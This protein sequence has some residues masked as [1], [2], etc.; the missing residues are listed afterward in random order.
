MKRLTSIFLVLAMLL[1]LAPMNI[2]A[3]ESENTAFSDMKITDYYA[4][5]ATV[6]EELG[7]ISGYPD[8]TYGAEKSITRAEMAAIICRII[9]K[10]ADADA[11][12]GETAFDDVS[13][14]H[15]ASGYI[16]VA[17]KLGIINGD[18]DGNFRPEDEVKFEEAIKMLVCALGYAD[19]VE[20]DENDWSKAYLEIAE[21]KGIT[22]SLQGEK[23]KSATRGDIAV[24]SYNG[25]SQITGISAIPAVPVASVSGGEYE[26]AQKVKLTTITEGAEIYYTTD[27]TTPTEKSVKYTKEISISKTC[28]LKAVAVKNGVA[29]KEILSVDYTIL[30]GSTHTGRRNS[31]SSGSSSS[32]Y[33]VTFDLNYDG[34]TGTPASQSVAKDG[35]AT[36][37][38]A[39]VR[40]GYSFVGWYMDNTYSTLF[41]FS[42]P[43][44]SDCTVFARWIDITDSTDTDG[45]GLSDALE[46]YYG[47]DAA[48]A[49]TDGDGLTD[50][51]EIKFSNTNPLVKDSDE[52][53]VNDCDED[54]D[55]D[56]LKNIEE[57]AYNCNP[58][59]NDTDMDG[60]SDYDEIKVYNTKPD[61]EDTDGDGLSDGDEIELGLNPL[62]QK[63]DGE[64]LD[65]QR[66]FAQTL[67]EENISDELLSAE[68]AA[69]PSLSMNVAGNIESNT[70]VTE[71][72]YEVLSANKAVVGTP[73]S[74]STTADIS[75]GQATISFNISGGALP[76][77]LAL[78]EAEEDSQYLICK[79]S[80][81][82]EETEFE[83]L[84]TT[85]EN[86]ILSA[87][88]DSEGTYF[89][90]DT[91]SFLTNL[92][93]YPLDYFDDAEP[94]MLMSAA[95]ENSEKTLIPHASISERR[96]NANKKL[97]NVDEVA[98]DDTL[99]T[100]EEEL[101]LMSAS[102]DGVKAQADIVFIIDKTGS[103]FSAIN[104]VALNVNKFADDLVNKYK[105][106]ANFSIIEFQDITHDGDDSTIQHKNG[107]SNWWNA[108]SVNLFKNEINGL[109]PDDGGD[110]P[111]TPIDG[112]GMARELVASS[113]TQKFFILITDAPYKEDNNYGV[114]N[115][116]QMIDLLKAD[117]INVSVVTDEWNEWE[118][119]ESVGYCVV[120]KTKY[121]E[122]YYRLTDVYYDE[123]EGKYFYYDED[124]ETY[125]ETTVY[126]DKSQVK[127][128]EYVGYIRD[129]DGYYKDVYYNKEAD[130]YYSISWTYDEATNSDIYGEVDVIDTSAI[131]FTSGD[132]ETGKVVGYKALYEKT[133]G[134]FGNIYDSNFALTLD[135]IAGMIDDDV[136]DG[137]WI[138]LDNFET[139]KLEKAPAA[140]S[141][142]DTDKDGIPDIEELTT[143]SKKNV[144]MYIET[145][146]TSRGLSY[147]EYIRRGGES[148]INVYSFKSNPTKKDTDGDGIND[149][150]D[151]KPR[152][153]NV[154]DRH[155][156]MFA[157]LSYSSNDVSKNTSFDTA[158]LGY[159]SID[160]LS[161]WKLIDNCI[162]GTSSKGEE[163]FF[164][165]NTYQNTSTKEIVVAFRG[166]SDNWDWLE[167]GM[168]LI[169]GKPHPQASDAENYINRI[170]KKYI[171]NIYI[172]GHSLGGYLA[173]YAAA[174]I[175]RDFSRCAVFNA[176]GMDLT[177]SRDVIKNL[178]AN[179]SKIANYRV[180]GDVVSVIG[181]H[182]GAE[183]EYTPN[184]DV[185]KEHGLDDIE[186]WE[187]LGKLQKDFIVAVHDMRHFFT[188]SE[189]G[190]RF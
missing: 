156:A 74:I 184:Y 35:Y 69:I 30:N 131:V 151:A 59:S 175:D 8:G 148:Y 78:D 165:A 168:Y 89:V 52:N 181:T 55:L 45:D 185:L 12:K 53:G 123:A 186:W 85:Y 134:V 90:L 36:S 115:M 164:A 32:N 6:L 119:E 108:R 112:L 42:A 14:E 10:Q 110:W 153:F 173:A 99:K 87:S 76:A 154:T 68:N 130:R 169:P 21:E 133:G 190:S 82:E 28:T 84:E 182:Y 105:I 38:S 139:I 137:S 155:L 64:T 132:N 136:N 146:L 166:T 20:I 101:T 126:I 88:I 13:S 183:Y 103:M 25:I 149:K 158:S 43:I 106:N 120:T 174:T 40:D 19:G 159:A 102:T 180:E 109:I 177:A 118:F 160:E 51:F 81:D 2:F 172:T 83:P 7:I 44:T 1:T 152:W 129:T 161:G 54:F 111:E 48:N 170:A 77:M 56:G 122:T 75:S 66:T 128:A 104:N 86:G 57:Q 189:L 125:E 29:S 143:S 61:E 24:M 97:E 65:S 67:S 96:K 22:E 17:S 31:S 73:V 49:D 39:P 34:A 127:F 58:Y 162:T 176:L 16:N 23:G 94:A 157:K 9:D 79:Y 33:T 116:N 150:E 167:N 98:F 179:K 171:S 4:E 113:S 147:D 92:G 41:D 60:L 91:E 70:D 114:E 188:Y 3:A 18:G 63:T 37:P 124:T 15:W 72:G 95:E 117:G 140:G 11:A 62:M 27:G 71:A 107:V 144:R 121:G 138:V 93:I 5:A 163:I 187:Y 145:Y 135:L 142:T 178:K 141:D 26:K 50:Y 80:E 100:L 46:A 47:T